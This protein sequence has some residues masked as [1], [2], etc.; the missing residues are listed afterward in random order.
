MKK[1]LTYGTFDIL[2]IGHINLLKRAKQLG[3]Y[4]IVGVST[5]EFN[6]IKG[7]ESVFCYEDRKRIVESLE[8]VDEVIEEKNWNQKEEDIKKYKVNTFVMGNDW[9][10]KFDYLNELCE[11]KYLPRTEGI[12]TSKIKKLFNII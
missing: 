4:L 9:E 10:K 2:H 1:I 8:F 11:V 6:K 3:D 5:D 7:K 12:S